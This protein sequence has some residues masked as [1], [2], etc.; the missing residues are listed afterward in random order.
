MHSTA[1]C[2]VSGKVIHTFPKN[3]TYWDEG[4]ISLSLITKAVSV[5]VMHEFY[6]RRA[7][8]R[9]CSLL[10]LTRHSKDLLNSS[11]SIHTW[12]TLWFYIYKRHS[13]TIWCMTVL[14]TALTVMPSSI[15]RLINFIRYQLQKPATH[16]LCS[17]VSWV[18]LRPIIY[19][20]YI[21][22]WWKSIF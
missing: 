16:D 17:V 1:L 15:C 6:K 7:W 20:L 14:I 5:L 18:W 11:R 10:V 4:Q 9:V 2:I 21:M 8:E 22:N 13:C 12:T 19:K 3:I